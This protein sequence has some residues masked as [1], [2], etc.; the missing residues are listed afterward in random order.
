MA[1]AEDILSLQ[2]VV[3]WLGS[4][5]CERNAELEFAVGMDTRDPGSNG[6]A[7]FWR[8]TRPPDGPV[9][10]VVPGSAD[11]EEVC[12]GKGRS[13]GHEMPNPLQTGLRAFSQDRWVEELQLPIGIVIGVIE[14]T[15]FLSFDG[16]PSLGAHFHERDFM[17]V[18]QHEESGTDEPI[19][20]F[21]RVCHG[22]AMHKK[23]SI[24]VSSARHFASFVLGK[25]CVRADRHQA[26]FVYACGDI[27]SVPFISQQGKVPVPLFWFN[28]L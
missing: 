9:W 20:A 21:Q 27:A 26:H 23:F 16:H 22:R 25:R 15:I 18:R 11:R 7:G 13:L 8:V 6:P 24:E 28:Q 17:P 3:G 12:Q 5:V 14:H 4:R 10:A 19:V 1:R 2:P